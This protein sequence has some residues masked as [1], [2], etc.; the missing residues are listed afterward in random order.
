MGEAWEQLYPFLAES[1]RVDPTPVLESIIASTIQKAHDVAELREATLA[2][3]KEALVRAAWAMAQRFAQ[4]GKLLAFGNGGSAT[5]AQDVVTD[6]LNPPFPHWRPL[7]AIALVNDT[8]IVTAVGNDVGYESV[9]LRQVIA[10]GQ[11]QDIAMGISTSGNSLNVLKAL[12]Q[13][14]R[15][16]LLT[17]ALVGYDGGAIGRSEAVDFCILSPSTYVPRIQE[18][19]ATAYHA[20]LELVQTCLQRLSP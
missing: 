16:G 9:F 15:Q 14:K 7:P 8:A 11:P 12:E 18:A 20:L 1:E 5:D 2:Q 17:V 13:A 19:Q 4:G 6:F 10:Y 3:S